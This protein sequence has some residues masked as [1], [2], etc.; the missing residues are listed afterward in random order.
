MRTT[1]PPTGQ[2]VMCV[3][4]HGG[5]ELVDAEPRSD[6]PERLRSVEDWPGL[7]GQIAASA[8]SQRSI[9][10]SVVYGPTLGW[11]CPCCLL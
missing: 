9:G 11:M 1:C 3:R 6:S 5:R 8:L 7:P 4:G 10:L 2:N